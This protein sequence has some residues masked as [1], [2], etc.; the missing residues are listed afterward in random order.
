M[1]TKNGLRY[2]E[3]KVSGKSKYRIVMD[4]YHPYEDKWKQVTCGSNSVTKVRWMPQ[5]LNLIRKWKGF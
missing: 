5:K 2:Y 3:E 4:Y 1:A